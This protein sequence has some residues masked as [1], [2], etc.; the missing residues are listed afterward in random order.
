LAILVLAP[1]GGTLHIHENVLQGQE[2]KHGEFV[3]GQLRL[4]VS[5]ESRVEIVH[6]EWI[7]K[8]KRPG[9]FEWKGGSK[10]V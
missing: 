8:T 3:L 4:L 7:N 2:W 9:S 5:R 1:S 6:I 10:Q